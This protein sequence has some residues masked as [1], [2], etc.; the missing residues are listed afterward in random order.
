MGSLPPCFNLPMLKDTSTHSMV[1]HRMYFPVPIFREEETLTVEL[2]T[3]S[4]LF[5]PLSAPRLLSNFSLFRGSSRR[6]PRPPVGVSASTK[7]HVFQLS[8]AE[9]LLLGV[10]SKSGNKMTVSVWN[11]CSIDSI[12]IGESDRLYRVK[13]A[14]RSI[15]FTY[16]NSVLDTH[17]VMPRQRARGEV[18]KARLWA[19]R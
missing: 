2:P 18:L 6:R 19:G 7:E 3:A 1:N 16:S 5:F 9:V 4:S 10:Q 17:C 13:R 14:K 15:N 12:Q 11:W 8:M